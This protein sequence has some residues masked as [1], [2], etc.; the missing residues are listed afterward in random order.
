MGLAM[1]TDEQLLAQ[2]W[3]QAQIDQYRTEQAIE[4]TPKEVGLNEAIPGGGQHVDRSQSTASKGGFTSSVSDKTQTVLVICMLVL[5][6]LS[7]YSTLFAEGPQGP[8]G[9]AGE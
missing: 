7:M 5:F 4:E 6:P 2:G 9:D 3:T 8:Q 1:W